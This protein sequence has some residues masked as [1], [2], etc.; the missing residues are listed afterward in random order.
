MLAPSGVLENYQPQ[1]ITIDA[2]SAESQS[3]EEASQ[4]LLQDERIEKD[5]V[6]FILKNFFSLDENTLK[7]WGPI[8]F[9]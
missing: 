4:K 3:A 2:S 8:D 7:S 6:T 1:L 9:A 5:T